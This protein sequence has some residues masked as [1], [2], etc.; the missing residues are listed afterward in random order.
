MSDNSEEGFIGAFNRRR[1]FAKASLC[2]LIA[3]II[4]HYVHRDRIALNQSQSVWVFL[5]AAGIYVLGNWILC[6]CP[7]CGRFIGI[8]GEFEGLPR[9]APCEIESR[10]IERLDWPEK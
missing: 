4:V 7:G 8:A 6:R 5:F 2:L 3:V 10:N 9:G 1:L